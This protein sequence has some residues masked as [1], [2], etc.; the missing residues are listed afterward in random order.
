MPGRRPVKKGSFG[1]HFDELVTHF[2]HDRSPVLNEPEA[3]P[4]PD[5][6]DIHDRLF[7]N[8]WR[9]RRDSHRPHR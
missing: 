9:K 7:E 4:A 8:A 6:K 2:L 5:P 3:D 1:S